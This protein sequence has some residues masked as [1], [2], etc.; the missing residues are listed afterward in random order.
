MITIL[1]FGY[2]YPR[3]EPLGASIII[4]ARS[5]EHDPML[6]GLSTKT[7]LDPQ[8]ADYLTT[9]PEVQ[10]LLTNIGLLA[11]GLA[12]NETLAIGCH[13]GRHRSVYLANSIGRFMQRG[14]LPVD[15]KHLDIDQ[16]ADAPCLTNCPDTL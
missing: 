5:L 11:L 1:S 16:P 6:A 14:L 9:F 2:K 3:T 10:G 15:I 4:D 7:G 8:V 12:D 13:S